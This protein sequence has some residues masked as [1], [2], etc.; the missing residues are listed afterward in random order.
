M[1]KTGFLDLFG[2]GGLNTG[3]TVLQV[4]TEK[5]IPDFLA[6]SQYADAVADTGNEGLFSSICNELLYSE[7]NITMVI[8]L[9]DNKYIGHFE[10]NGI[11]ETPEI[12]IEL[13]ED[14][15]KQGFGYEVCKAMVDF[16][17]DNTD[18]SSLF[19]N[20]YRRN[21]P[22]KKLA[23]KLGAARVG[24]NRVSDKVEEIGLCKEFFEESQ[25]FDLLLYEIRKQNSNTD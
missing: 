6:N 22:S 18:V 21:I 19:Y 25:E 15:H 2:G 1:T 11:D 5:D 10:L 23:M 9:T 24:I 12:G 7:S 16:I 4:M 17:F 8:R 14:Y 13:I 3:R 20:C